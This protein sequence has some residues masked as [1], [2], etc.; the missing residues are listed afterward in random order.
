MRWI[1]LAV[2]LVSLFFEASLLQFPLVLAVVIVA[3]AISDLP[4]IF[5]VSVF[6]GFVLDGMTFRTIGSTSIFFL[7][8]L[9]VLATYKRKFELQSPFFIFTAIFL[10]GLLYNVLFGYRFGL[11]SSVVTAGVSTFFYILFLGRKTDSRFLS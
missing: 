4:F 2:L 6:A 7:I 9:F 1:F 10:L 8:S 11:L 5:L 3:A